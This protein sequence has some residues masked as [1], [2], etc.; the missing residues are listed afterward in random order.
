M[1]PSYTRIEQLAKHLQRPVP[2][3]MRMRARLHLLDWIGCVAGARRSPVATIAKAAEP[4][5]LTRAALLGNVLEMDDIHRTAILHPGP[6]IWPAV[7]SAV[8][9]VNGGMDAL[10]DG[11]V[12]GYEAMIAVGATFDAHHYAHYHPTSTAGGFGAA[13]AA[14]SVFGNDEAVLVSAMGNAGSA[15][16]GLWQMRHED[17]MTKQLHVT[18]VA[19]SGLWFARL[20]A[21]GFT[22]P[23][24]VLEG[25][26]GLY[27][28]SVP[29]PRPLILNDGWA[30]SDV[31]FKPWAA[32]RH[33]H[34]AIDAALMLKG[35]GKLVPPI[36]VETYRDAI[37]F[38]NRPD[39]RTELDAKFSLQHAVAVAALGDPADP[40]S[41]TEDVFHNPDIAAFR[42]QVS[43]REATEIS[44][45]YP[46]H[47]G[48]RVRSTAGIAECVDTLGDPE[49]PLEEAGIMVKARR[50]FAW[51]KAEDADS[52]IGAAMHGTA[53]SAILDVLGRLT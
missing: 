23:K 14:V 24:A 31:S 53:P 10:L 8:R 34:P 6:V 37:Q 9:D 47:Y 30:M 4:D 16:G 42:E 25:P 39:P 46:S 41:Y 45:R 50:L 1:T 12:R 11:A 48:A 13:A 52:A 32:C 35:E 7:L 26:Q 33:A 43:V 20:A 27:A 44:A 21:K 29:D 28:A 51:G 22:G 19:L 36:R 40:A 17:V 38:C 3:A 15:S 5:V 2:E 49:R 18:H